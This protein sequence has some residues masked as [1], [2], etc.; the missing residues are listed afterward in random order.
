VPPKEVDFGELDIASQDV[1]IELVRAL[2][3]QLWMPSV[4]LQTKGAH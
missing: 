2:E 4:Q 1:Q 3:E